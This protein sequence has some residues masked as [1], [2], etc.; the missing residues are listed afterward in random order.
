MKPMAEAATKNFWIVDLDEYTPILVTAHGSVVMEADFSLAQEGMDSGDRLKRLI[1]FICSA[2]RR[3][4][5]CS[6]NVTVLMPFGVSHKVAEEI[7]YLGYWKNYSLEFR[8]DKAAHEV[9]VWARFPNQPELNCVLDQFNGGSDP[10]NELQGWWDF[11]NRI[12]SDHAEIWEIHLVV[13][14]HVY[15]RLAISHNPNVLVEIQTG[16]STLVEDV[17]TRH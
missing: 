3:L 13:N 5:D 1:D 2:K 6:P 9:V 12:I 11:F 10:C 8:V 17:L 15:E 14:E 7:V 4:D 16:E